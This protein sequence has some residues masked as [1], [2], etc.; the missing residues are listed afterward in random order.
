MEVS[1]IY[2]H[3]LA[4]GVQEWPYC[5]D[6]ITPEEAIDHLRAQD[7]AIYISHPYANPRG[8]KNPG[9]VWTPNILKRLDFDGIEWFNAQ[10]Y[11]LN[12][13]TQRIYK[14]IPRGRRIA[15]TDAHHPLAFGYAYTQVDIN[16]ENPDD[17][18]SAMQKGKCT[19]YG[20]DVPPYIAVYTSMDSISRNFLIRRRLIEGRW[21]KAMG[22]RVGSIKPDH[23]S[24]PLQW[25][26]DLLLNT[27]L[28]PRSVD[29]I[30]NY[31]N[32]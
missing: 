12:K 5:R 11:V 1:T 30:D 24:N 28:N 9:G 4:Y 10:S 16:S 2:N 7:C 15:G 19:P 13:K 27:P 22:D 25:K 23:I 31:R 14:N 26:K 20:R 21:T 32:Y 3:F 8:T 18:V 6:S 17:L 29:W